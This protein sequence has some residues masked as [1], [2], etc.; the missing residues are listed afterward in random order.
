M[1]PRG[2]RGSFVEEMCSHTVVEIAPTADLT[3][4]GR[5]AVVA[6]WSPTPRVTLS[7][8][9]LIGE[10]SANGYRCV[11]VST[12]QGGPLEWPEG[13]PPGTVVLRRANEGYDFGSWAVGLE[14]FPD[15]RRARH[16]IL[17]NDSM[18][19]PF[20]P[21]GPLLAAFESAPTDVWAVTDS[22]QITHHLQSYFVGFNHGVLDEAPW[23]RFFRSVRHHEEKMDIVMR[24]EIAI[25]G[26]CRT[27]GYPWTAHYRASDVG[28]GLENPTLA[29]WRQLLSLGF[30]FVKRT[31]ITDPSTAPGGD[32]V[33]AVVRR[34][35]GTELSEWL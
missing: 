15:A 12:A 30:P 16:V 26:V 10:L 25:M 29:G 2:G 22:H 35:Y 33:A 20:E 34:K 31:I 8:A 24:Y 4:D 3:A 7:M 19:G 28:V 6:H 32:Q 1:T 23:R 17:T 27:E 9:R 11:V 5:V 14:L 21:I 13:P 18:A